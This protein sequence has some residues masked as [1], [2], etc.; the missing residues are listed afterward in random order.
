MRGFQKNANNLCFW[1]FWVKMGQIGPKKSHFRIFGEKVKTSPSLPIFYFQNRKF[2]N[3]NARFRI[4]S[5]ERRQRDRQR[6][7][8][9]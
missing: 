9:E 5:V 7:R 8:E 1:A 2:E 4:K 6:D 3:S